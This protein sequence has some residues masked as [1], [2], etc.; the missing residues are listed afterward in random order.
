MSKADELLKHSGGTLHA[1]A[2]VRPG[3]AG[4]ASVATATGGRDTRK[5]GLDRSKT[6]W[7]I[8]LDRIE[9]DPGQ[10]REE[11]SAGEIERLAESLKAHGLLQPITVRWAEESGRYRI[12]SGERRYRA[13]TLAGW[14][15]IGCNVIERPLEPDELLTLQLVENLMREDLKPIEQAR[16]FRSLLTVNGWSI[17][18]LAGQMGVSQ[19]AVSQSLRLLD[20]PPSIQ[21]RVESGDLAPVSAYHI[22]KIA[23]PAG[24]AEIAERAIS[25]GLTRDEVVE[26]VG[27]KMDAN[28]K[29]QA[30][31]RVGGAKGKGASKAK[32]KPKLPTM[33]TIK[34]SAGFRVTVEHRKG[35]DP[36]G[37]ATAL[38]EAA[39]K[40]RAEMEPAEGQAAA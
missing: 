25:Q 19:S 2:S 27:E 8:P 3:P 13:A 6:A 20:L 33:K 16:A 29:P 9:R 5:E 34:T 31:A 32:A 14:D 24:Q 30:K 11:F 10:P 28:P 39:A 7:T 26:A 18:K 22:A 23:D 38:E 15:G 12:V 37:L 36:A 40:V 1:S 4:M 21:D 35:F 17:T